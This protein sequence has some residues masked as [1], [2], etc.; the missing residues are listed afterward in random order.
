MSYHGVKIDFNIK[1]EYQKVV[2]DI[3]GEIELSIG[4]Y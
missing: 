3:L 1:S 4:T 2:S